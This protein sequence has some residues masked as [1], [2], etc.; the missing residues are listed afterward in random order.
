MWG[1]PV[2]KSLKRAL[3]LVVIIL[4]AITIG[5]FVYVGFNV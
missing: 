5:Y 1:E 4:L 3:A 2:N